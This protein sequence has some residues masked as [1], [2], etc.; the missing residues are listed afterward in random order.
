MGLEEERGLPRPKVSD[1]VSIDMS[2]SQH[3]YNLGVDK[4]TPKDSEG[5]PH[6]YNNTTIPDTLVQNG[7]GQ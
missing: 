4:P 3:E 1:D 5:L 6:Y 7:V 2:R